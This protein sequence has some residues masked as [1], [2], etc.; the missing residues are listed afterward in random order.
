MAGK[1]YGIDLGTTTSSIA[2]FDGGEVRIIKNMEGAETTPS[3]VFFDGVD[4][5]GIDIPLVGSQAKNMAATDPDH[6]IQF[7]KRQMGE[8]GAAAGIEAPSGKTYTPEMISALIL[9]KVCQ[10][11]SEY[12]GG[13]VVQDVVITVP[14]YFDDARRTATIQAGKIAGLNVLHVINEPT[15]AA[16]AYGIDQKKSG[17]ILVYDLGG[18]T[19]DVTV[20]DINGGAFDVI[21]TGGDPKLGGINFDAELVGMIRSKLARQHCEIDDTDDELLMEIREKAEAAKIQLSSVKLARVRFSIHDQYYCV[22]ITRDEFEKRAAH[23][24][25]RTVF[26]LSDVLKEKNLEWK[27]IDTLL[28][29]GG[30]TKMP[31]VKAKLEELFG[32]KARYLVDPD[33]AVAQGAA[34]FASTLKTSEGGAG[35]APEEVNIISI[36][37]VTS[38]SLGVVTVDSRDNLKEVNTVII[39][40]NTKIP[41]KQ[42]V[43]VYTKD[44][45]QTRII[46][47][48]TE[49]NDPELEYVRIIGSTT[50]PIPPYPK[51]SPVEIIYAYDLDQTI[52]I[53]V[54]DKVANRSLGTFEVDRKSNLS[55][56]QLESAAGFIQNITVE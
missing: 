37:D 33:T 21:A 32:Q 8:Q 6:V 39:P 23:L 17:R 9:K 53:E 16:I 25:Q 42:S 19:F 29:V 48:V 27:D 24:L 54:V 56:Q 40:N 18:G 43:T 7:I 51:N 10:D 41:A 1:V 35:P 36:S 46:V 3:V 2:V 20:M 38:Q 49:G 12:D 11:T 30:S 26:L 4:E 13:E 14:A 52:F 31:M 44:D 50:L 28:V 47:E 45:N 55:K 22:E 5:N 15:A 34:I